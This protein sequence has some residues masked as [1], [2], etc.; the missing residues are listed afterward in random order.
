[1][2]AKAIVKVSFLG[3]LCIAQGIANAADEQ[4]AAPVYALFDAMREHDGEKLVQQFAET[5]LLHRAQKDGSIKISDLQKF[6]DFVS[7]SDKY[8]DEHLLS[9]TVM[10]QDNLASVWTPYVFYLDHT[11]SHCGV[12]S[13]QLVEQEQEWKIQYLIDNTHMGDCEEFVKKYRK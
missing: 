2:N 7:K 13:F 5:A 4:I 1:M 9:V 6:A 8:L 3:L 11:L 12:N 10:K